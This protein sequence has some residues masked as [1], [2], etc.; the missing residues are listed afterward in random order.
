[1]IRYIALVRNGVT[2]AQ[3]Q[4]QQIGKFLACMRQKLDWTC[5]QN[6]DELVVFCRK[7]N[8]NPVEFQYL[9]DKG[10]LLLGKVFRKN[11]T[12]DPSTPHCFRS[13]EAE[14]M[15]KTKG[16]SLVDD[17]WGRYIAFISDRG[18]NR[19]IVVRDPTGAIPCY[20]SVIGDSTIIFSHAEDLLETALYNPRMNWP[21]IST[22]ILYPRLET[23]ETGLS[24]VFELQG[25]EGLEMSNGQATSSLLWRPVEICRS[26]VIDDFHSAASELE[27]TVSGCARTWASCYQNVI[28]SLSGGLDSAIVLKYLRDVLDRDR[29]TCLNFHSPDIPESDERV[30]ARLVANQF[31]SELLELEFSNLEDLEELYTLPTT[32]K[33][34]FWVFGLGND[35]LLAQIAKERN[36]DGVSNGSGGDQLFYQA[37]TALI[38][39]DYVQHKGLNLKLLEVAL[40]AAQLTGQPIWTVLRSAVIHGLL[41]RPSNPHSFITKRPHFMRDEVR[42]S[43]D[44]RHFSHLWLQDQKGVPAGKLLQISVLVDCFT[45]FGPFER[46]R[47]SDSINPLVS[48]PIMETCL[49]IPSYVFNKGGID[50]ALARTAFSGFLP[51]ELL[52]RTSKGE[53]SRVMQRLFLNNRHFIIDRLMNGTL[54]SEGILDRKKIEEFFSPDRII[55]PGEVNSIMGCVCTEIWV[56]KWIDKR[57]REAA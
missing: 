31:D 1:M 12:P 50:R 16:G 4:R 14:R 38:A 9:D 34:A 32:T 35:R 28:H 20:Y 44:K 33:P 5:V 27:K 39:A 23:G 19:T 8:P 26:D 2:S 53:T 18:G 29:L 6:S 46:N 40:D 48:Q 22:F 43:I 15:C 54:Q 56:E 25:G 36:V 30:F 13:D 11:D 10:G 3:Q 17:F 57:N 41:G 42:E 45:Y 24:D 51:K 7:K 37:H 47:F 21:F 55:R 52:A 49:R